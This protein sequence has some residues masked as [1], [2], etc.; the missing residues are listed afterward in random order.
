M[1]ND[2]VQHQIYNKQCALRKRFGNRVAVYARFHRWSRS[3]AFAR[4]FTGLREQQATGE[5]KDCFG[6]DSCSGE[7][8]FGGNGAQ[9]E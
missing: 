3:G 8:Y 5:E 9:K 7:V 6:L 4:L 2:Q 1:T